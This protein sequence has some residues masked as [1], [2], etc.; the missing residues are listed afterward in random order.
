VRH[1]A[2]QKFWAAYEALP[3]QIRKLADENYEL[4]KRDHV[5]HPY[6]SKK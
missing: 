1:F 3:S 4:L 5:T 2:S 6:S